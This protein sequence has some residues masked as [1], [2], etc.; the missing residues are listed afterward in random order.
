MVQHVEAIV[1]QRI[2][3]SL[4]RRPVRARCLADSQASN[5]LEV[6]HLGSLFCGTMIQ[7]SMPPV[8]GGYA[9]LV[10]FGFEV[11]ATRRHASLPFIMFYCW[12]QLKA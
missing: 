12:V 11:M 5:A 4:Y 8:G 3:N 1:A 7:R 2:G 6:G 9:S 10:L